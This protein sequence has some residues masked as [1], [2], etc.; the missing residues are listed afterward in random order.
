MRD[1]INQSLILDSLFT[2]WK[3]GF[4]FDSQLPSNFLYLRFSTFC[5]SFFWRTDAIVFATCVNYRI[6][7]VMRRIQLFIRRNPNFLTQFFKIDRLKIKPKYPVI[8][9]VQLWFLVMFTLTTIGY[10]MLSNDA[11]YGHS[12]MWTKPH[13]AYCIAIKSKKII[14]INTKSIIF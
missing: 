8:I 2:N 10:G 9:M 11:D 12:P 4:V 1:C 7:S 13:T 5:Y 6:F 3:F 14:P